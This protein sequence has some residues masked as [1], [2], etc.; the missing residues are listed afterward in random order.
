MCD[1][2]VTP[3]LKHR[4]NYSENFK[5]RDYKRI[6]G[7]VILL[8]A[9]LSA[10]TTILVKFDKDP[11]EA[12]RLEDRVRRSPPDEQILFYNLEPRI[13][14]SGIADQ[15]PTEEDIVAYKRV[16]SSP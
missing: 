10:V 3:A 12:Q 5:P 16:R 2:C 14:A 7:S 13:T 9:A 4:L 15:T 6:T 11:Q 1:A 8:T